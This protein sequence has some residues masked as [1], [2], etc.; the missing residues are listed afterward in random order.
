VNRFTTTRMKLKGKPWELAG[1]QDGGSFTIKSM[2]MASHGP[3]D[4]DNDFS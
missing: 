3:Y 2:V 1:S 4:I